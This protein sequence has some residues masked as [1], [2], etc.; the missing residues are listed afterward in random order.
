MCM[1]EPAQGY[2]LVFKFS[3]RR[4]MFSILFSRLYNGNEGF[5]GL[6]LKKNFTETVYNVRKYSFTI[7]ER[8]TKT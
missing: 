5:G 2:T 1:D 8:R 4:R 6:T 7:E 3:S